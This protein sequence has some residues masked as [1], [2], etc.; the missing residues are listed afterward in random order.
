TDVVLTEVERLTRL[1]EDIL[2]M[3]RIDA[4]AV[5]PDPQWVHPS[6]IV[7]TARDNLGRT[8][9]EHHLEMRAESDVLVRLDPRLTTAA[10]AQLIENAARYSPDASVIDVVARVAG[11]E[12][13]ITVRD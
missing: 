4:G 10:L 5:S 1:F 12:L 11:G 2:D 13:L 7:D 6:Q 3:A 9:Q 8:L